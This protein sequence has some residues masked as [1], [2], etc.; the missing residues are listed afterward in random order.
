MAVACRV[1]RKR[2]YHRARM[3]EIA[4]EARISYGLVYHYYKNK[5]DLFDAI[6]SQWWEGLYR[7]ADEKVNDAATIY[8]K[9]EL[10]V[11]YFLDKYE[12][13]P[14]IVHLF[15]AEVSRSTANLTK[16][17]LDT[18]KEWVGR[19]EKVLK[20]AQ[21]DGELRSDIPASYLT[22][23]FLGSLETLLSTMV[24][25]NKPLSGKARKSRMAKSF[26]EQFFN[27]AAPPK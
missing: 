9:L 1:F 8:E 13:E 15:V 5:A 3:A 6:L 4:K 24:L 2:G 25:D 7:L 21:A 16:A 22:T 26:L 14:D 19:T 17:R 11:N 20:Q 27:G 18:L 12:T 23:F 10:V